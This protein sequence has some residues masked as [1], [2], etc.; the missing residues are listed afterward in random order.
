[1]KAPL[2]AIMLVR[3]AWLLALVLG[4]LFWGRYGGPPI[5][6]HMTLG[7]LVVIGMWWLGLI[8][9]GRARGLAVLALLWGVL[10]PVVGLA[11]LGDLGLPLTAVQVAHV[12]VNVVA[13][14]LAE[15]LAGRLRRAGV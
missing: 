13:I 10:V 2:F 15:A 12:V 9:I 6:V 5:H 14:G 1:M 11:Q 4:V 8:G 3:L 7:G